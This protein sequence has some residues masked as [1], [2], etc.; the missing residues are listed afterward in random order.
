MTA[1]F[2]TLQA[3]NT[4]SER[5]MKRR[6]IVAM[7]LVCCVSFGLAQDEVI[8]PKRARAAK[9][10]LFVGFTPGVIFPKLGSINSFLKAGHAA[11]LSEN[12]M[13]LYGGGG[14]IYIMVLPNVRIGGVGMSGSLSSTALDAN[15]IR[16]DTQLKLGYGGVTIEYVVPVFE[17]MVVAVGGMLG[18]G[19]IDLTLRQS[20]G[21]SNTWQGEQ[22]YLGGGLGAP[23]ANVTRVLTGSFFVFVPSLN[24]EYTVLPW[25]AVRTGVSY[26]VMASPTWKVDGNYDLLGV[27]SDV[28]GRGAQI[29]LAL[30]VGLF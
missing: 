4:L 22:D 14:A 16:R 5:F 11:P 13:F 21:L 30:L 26:A 20:N 28:S 18:G 2:F 7:L 23:Q 17:R 19:G 10:G 6:S 15:N 24:V 8:P 27:P 3:T 25:M 29:N 12:G 9:V 1:L